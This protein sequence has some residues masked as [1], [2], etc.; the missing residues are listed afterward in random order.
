MKT[1][2]YEF[3]KVGYKAPGE[4]EYTFENTPYLH[5]ENAASAAH[6]K[7]VVLAT[8]TCIARFTVLQVWKYNET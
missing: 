7:A 4:T 3:F 5:M 2:T 8:Q 1:R 6:N